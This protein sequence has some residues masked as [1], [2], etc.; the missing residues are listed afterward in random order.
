M[1]GDGSLSL[2]DVGLEAAQ[3]IY[4][5]HTMLTDFLISLGVSEKTAVE[6]ACKMEHYISNET[7]EAM[8]HHQIS[9]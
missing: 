2:T 6:D 4:E 9:N 3:K 7:F 5:R 8:K 1:D